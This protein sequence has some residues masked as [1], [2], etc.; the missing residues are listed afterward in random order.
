MES[1]STLECG[2]ALLCT[3]SLKASLVGTS[4][5]YSLVIQPYKQPQLKHYTPCITSRATLLR[6]KIRD[7]FP[8]P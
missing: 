7:T 2:V 8:L 5:A 3:G 1:K 4:Y 6:Q